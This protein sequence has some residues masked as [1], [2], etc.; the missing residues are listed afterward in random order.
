[1]ETLNLPSF[2]SRIRCVDD[3]RDEIWDSFRKKFVALTP[4][5]WVRQ[6][7]LHFLVDQR[8][9]PASLLGVEVALTVNHLARRCDILAWNR[10]GKPLMI[11]ECK[12]PHVEITQDAF[13]QVARYNL[14]LAAKFLVVTNG[15]RHYAC[16][17]D[18]IRKSWK[19][20]ADI[21]EYAPD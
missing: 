2:D 7:M 4:E 9:F 15:L 19:F 3:S 1:M 20:L 21:P 14:P 10:L 13:D 6:H 17:I 8:H 18:H 11:V 5:E 12:A 16:E